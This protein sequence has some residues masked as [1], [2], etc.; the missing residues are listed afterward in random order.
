MSWVS[1]DRLRV[2]LQSQG[3]EVSVVAWMGDGWVNETA[4]VQMARSRA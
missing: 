4:A 2:K 1:S 3:V